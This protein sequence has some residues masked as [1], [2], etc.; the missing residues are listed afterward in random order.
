MTGRQLD[1]G[2]ILIDIPMEPIKSTD[3]VAVDACV[4]SSEPKSNLDAQADRLVNYWMAKG[5]QVHP[6][7]KEVGSGVNDGR[8]KFIEWLSDTSRKTEAIVQARQ[9]QTDAA[10]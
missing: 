6:V 10:S 2:T 5:W 9:E 8:Q 4:A 1:T 7:I 3:K